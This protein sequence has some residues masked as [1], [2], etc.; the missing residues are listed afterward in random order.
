M[1]VLEIYNI[2]TQY[3]DA[4]GNSGARLLAGVNLSIYLAS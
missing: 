2:D 3:S 1:L 4:L